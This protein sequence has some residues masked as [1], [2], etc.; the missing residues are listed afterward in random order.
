MPG[1]VVVQRFL[2]DRIDAESRGAAVGGE[3][4]PVVLPAAHE[5]QAALALVELAEAR[6]DV[7]LNAAVEGR[8]QCRP[9]APSN[10]SG[11]V[12]EFMARGCA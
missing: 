10:R 2:L 4:D 9:A 1:Q 8:C 6:A 5:A 11:S 3:H 7:A 12:I